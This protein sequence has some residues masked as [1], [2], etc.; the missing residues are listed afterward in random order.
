MRQTSVRSIVTCAACV[1]TT[2]A[3]HN[4]NPEF[5]GR[6]SVKADSYAWMEDN[7]LT[8]ASTSQAGQGVLEAGPAASMC[9]A[10]CWCIANSAA[11]TKRNGSVYLSRYVQLLNAS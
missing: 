4:L 3:G 7:C 1:R 8:A 5:R 2:I 11:N 9:Q 10:V 6:T